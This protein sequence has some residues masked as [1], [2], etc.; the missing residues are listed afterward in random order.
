MEQL[1]HKYEN[2]TKALAT[3]KE[4]LDGLQTIKESNAA[5]K[6][7]LFDGPSLHRFMRDSLVQRFEYSTD[8]FWKYLKIYMEKRQLI[9]QANSPAAAIR[10]ACASG[11]ITEDEARNALN[12]VRDR[13]E[14]SHVY[15]EEVAEML[16]EKIPA[17]YTLMHSV[18]VRLK[19]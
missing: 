4:A 8:L 9:A 11:I 6:Q 3:V 13:N 19:P 2:F 12:M 5:M 7:C 10:E 1:N 14:T 16:L 15:H 17:Y 18:S